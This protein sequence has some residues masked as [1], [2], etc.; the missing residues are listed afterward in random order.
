MRPP[1]DDPTPGTEDSTPPAQAPAPVGNDLNSPSD[2]E[3]FV[4][5]IGASAGAL[6]PISELLKRLPSGSNFAT[7]LVQHLDPHHESILVDLLNRVSTLPVQWANHGRAVRPGQ[8]YVAP[9]KSCLS[10]EEGVLVIHQAD[11]AKMGG[12]IDYFFTSLAHDGKHRAVGVILS[13]NG[14]DGTAGAKAIKGAGGIVFAQEPSTASFASMPRSAIAAGC[15]DRVLPPS[16]IVDELLKLTQHAPLLWNRMAVSNETLPD[17]TEAE[18][19]GAILRLLTSR[20]GVN[21]SDYKPTTI[22]RRLVRQMVLS[23]C[24]HIGEYLK[25]LQKNRNELDHLYE[26]LLINVT[27][28]FRDPDYFEYLRDHVLPQLVAH[29]EEHLPIRMWAPGCSTGEEVYSLAILTREL[30]EASSQPPPV[31]IFGTDVSDRA[32]AV[33]RAGLYS[34]SEVTNVSPDRLRKFF[35]QTD[36]GF[37]ILKSIRDLCIFARQNVARDSPFSRLDLISCR[38]LLIYFGPGLQRKLMPVFHY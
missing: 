36:R 12:G 30:L 6:E 14:A 10:I 29:R 18:H 11:R 8:V 26:S 23:K 21:F 3:F 13:G 31:Q 1:H 4:V 22:K 27:E 16:G 25:R 38:N 19:L 32:I 17:G 28:F 2:R 35:H 34:P 33:A 20:T 5:G 7:V 24:P 15:V 37:V 9:P